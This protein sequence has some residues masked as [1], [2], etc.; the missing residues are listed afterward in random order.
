MAGF[1]Y[2]FERAA[3]EPEIH[4]GLAFADGAFLAADEM[5]RRRG[6]GNQKYPDVIVHAVAF[7]MLA[8]AE[9]VQ[10]VLRR[11]TQFAPEA[12]RDQAVQ[13]RRIRP[14]R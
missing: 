6:A 13:A 14:L 12:I 8:P 4:G 2:A 11:E 10:R 3:A 5:G 1:G 9:I 7:V